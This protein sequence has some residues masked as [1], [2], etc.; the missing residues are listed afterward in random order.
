MEVLIPDQISHKCRKNWLEFFEDIIENLNMEKYY[1][2]I[3]EKDAAKH[4]QVSFALGPSKNAS[5]V[6]KSPIQIN[7]T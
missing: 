6:P 4:F 1:E 7:K 2:D 5:D 3:F